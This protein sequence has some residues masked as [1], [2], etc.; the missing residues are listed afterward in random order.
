[1]I[2]IITIATIVWLEMIRKKDIY[3]LLILLGALL[4]AL[5][6]LNIF[7]I[8]GTDRYVKDVGLMM[9]W[10]FSLILAVTLSCR[11]I[12]Q[13]ESSG[14]VYPLLAKPVS[15]LEF[16]LGKWLGSWTV[17]SVAV[18]FFYL[19][20]MLVAALKGGLFSIGAIIQ[21][22]VLHL[23]AI[24]IITS[25]GLLFS[26][27]M[28]S[29]AATSM[30][31]VLTLT[32]FVI[33]PKVPAFM[34]ASQGLHS[35]LLEFI[36]HLLPHFEILDMRMRIIHNYGPISAASFLESTAYGLLMAL[37]FVMIAWLSYKNKRFSRNDTHG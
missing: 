9:A 33:T 30:T 3:V 12:P 32:A 29:D 17:I 23:C 8:A 6:S 13:E 20:I 36:Y 31:Y 27:R 18:F 11:A 7:G 25:I 19:L 34:A 2:R 14:T 35:I 22:F 15:R 16:I 10:I 37:V 21:G 4:C 1:M 26:T 24:G 28:N 5:V